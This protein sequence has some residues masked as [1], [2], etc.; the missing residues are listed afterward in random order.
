V[1]APWVVQQVDDYI[2]RL[3][4]DKEVSGL[5][6]KLLERIHQKLKDINGK[7]Q[8]STTWQRFNLKQDKAHTL[9]DLTSKNTNN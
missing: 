1:L 2:D 9:I 7:F 3:Q 6:F 8:V 5:D 4:E